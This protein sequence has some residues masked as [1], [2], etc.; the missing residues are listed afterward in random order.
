MPC[1]A[2][3]A[4]SWLLASK[5]RVIICS[6]HSNTAPKILGTCRLRGGGA[7][8]LSSE[9]EGTR[10]DALSRQMRTEAAPRVCSDL[11]AAASPAGRV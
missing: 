4:T 7:G 1:Q 5:L 6:V 10:A 9:R 2:M 3:C 11:H 8:A